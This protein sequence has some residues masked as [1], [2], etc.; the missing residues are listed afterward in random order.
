MGK[1]HG[2]GKQRVNVFILKLQWCFIMLALMFAN[3]TLA[4][5]QKFNTGWQYIGQEFANKAKVDS[6][7]RLGANWNDQFIIEKTNLADTAIVTSLQQE[8]LQLKGKLWQPVNLPH[9][10]F[11]EPLIIVKPREG[12]A[13]YKKQFPIAGNLK[14]KR[15]SIEFEA[16]MQVSEVW[17]NDQ[18][19]GRFTGGYLP[20]EIDITNVVKYGSNNEIVVKINNKANPVVPPGKPVE[21]LDFIYY[22]GIYRDVWLHIRNPVHITNALT[23]NKIAG[24]GIFITY[25]LVTN[26]KAI[27]EVQTHIENSQQEPSSFTIEQ[28][29]L[30]KTGKRVAFIS[31]PVNKLKENVDS[32]FVQRLELQNPSLWHPDHPYLY[33]LRTMVRNNNQMLDEQITKMG[34]RNF[35]ISK[36]EGLLINGV[37]FHITGTNRHQNYPYIGNALSNEASYRD[38]WL[39][40]AAG[41][42]AVRTAHYP[43]DPSFLEAAD[44][45]G[46]LIIDCIP[47]WQYYNKNVAFTDHVM[48]DIR[49]TI[50]RD[51]N[52]ACVL[53]WE[54]S[55]N[56]TYPSASFRCRQAEVAR[57]EWRG[58]N[59]FFTSGDSYFTKACWDVPYDDWNGDPGARNNTTYPDNAFLIREY[60]DYEFGGGSSTTRQL[61]AADEKG[62][63]Q[64]AWNLQWSHNKNYALYPRAIGDL[65]WAFYDGLAGASVGIEG[66]GVADIFRIPKYSYYFYKSQQPVRLNPLLPFAS[67]PVVFLATNWTPQSDP[68]KIVVYSNCEEV[69]LYLDGKLVAKQKPDN[70]PETGYETELSDGGQPFN[71]GN[72][73]RLLH[74]PFT[75][76]IT[77]FQ[78]GKIKAVGLIGG[79]PVKEYNVSTPGKLAALKLEAATNGKPFMAGGDVIFVYAKITDAKEQILWDAKLPITITLKGDAKLL[80]PV[81]VNAEAGIASF[82]MQSGAT[83]GTVT[84]NATGGGLKSQPFVIKIN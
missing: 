17:V 13:W 26:E 21:K 46:I 83:K 19:M 32:H 79:K 41:M 63:L 45:L 43:P 66:W 64:Q 14:G 56:E 31:T 55:L 54:V 72:A 35:S 9:T 29:L 71:G 60:G 25:P 42:N 23:A 50:R 36:N 4:Q 76:H 34:I 57:S 80:S 27:I 81:T 75:F 53:L 7:R 61:R 22:S 77:K 20:F 51:R 11:P 84:I 49:N 24:G 82:I 40:K 12:I 37:P 39:I 67:G 44:E 59:N 74:P 33:S 2:T 10:A 69:A 28:E 73:N 1:K 52:H 15:L 47:G 78:S 38:A 65:N 48:S 70:G 62:M 6:F 30:D 58:G 68:P 18:Y 8:L 5:S 3:K 16:A